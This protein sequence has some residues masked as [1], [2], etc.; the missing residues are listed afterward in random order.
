MDVHLARYPGAELDRLHACISMHPWMLYR[1]A[2]L[3]VSV[4]AQRQDVVGPSQAIGPPW[5]RAVSIGRHSIDWHNFRPS[6]VAARLI[7]SNGSMQSFRFAALGN[8]P[9]IG[10]EV[11]VPARPAGEI[12]VRPTL[13]VVGRGPQ[14]LPVGLDVPKHDC[15]NGSW[16]GYAI[17]WLSQSTTH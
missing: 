14:C 17:S 11:A 10:L 15:S 7:P 1:R 4:D 12:D 2:E 13:A 8:L 9:P 3:P 16:T 5:K 6:V